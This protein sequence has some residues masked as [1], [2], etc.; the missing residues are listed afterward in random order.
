M[1]PYL[2]VFYQNIRVLVMY[3]G[4][5]STPS[6]LKILGGDCTKED[7][8]SRVKPLLMSAVVVV[9]MMVVLV[10]PAEANVKSYEISDS[11]GVNPTLTGP[12]YNLGGGGPD[13]DSAIQWMINQARGCTSCSTEVDVVVIRSSGD[14]GYN[15]P[16]YNMKGVNSVETLVLNSPDDANR[17]DVVASVQNAEAIFFAGGNQ[18]DY[19]QNFKGTGLETAVESVVAGAGGIGG[20]SAG[21]M[22]QG[23]FVYNA[24]KGSVSSR[25]ALDDPYD[26]KISFTYDFFKWPNLESVIVDTHFDTSHRMGRLLTFVARQIQDGKADSVLGVG[27]EEGTSV[28]VDKKG[29]ARVRGEG[30]AYFVLGDHRPEECRPGRPLTVS[31]Y[32]VWKLNNGDTFDLKNRPTT[33]YDRVSVNDGQIE[34][35]RYDL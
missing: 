27:V 16:I 34:P 24:C 22:I 19:I 2:I 3:F 30:A 20:T 4:F 8:Q 17:P 11:P 14:D 13:V 23:N 12:A 5:R 15:E 25:E 18:C 26:S 29:L 21:A 28:V 10:S 31:D 35:D 33:G 1:P 32:K 9:L 7:V 6:Q